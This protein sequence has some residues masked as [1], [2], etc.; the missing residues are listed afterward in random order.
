[1][2]VDVAQAVPGLGQTLI[3]HP[4]VAIT[5]FANG[6]Y[7]YFKQ[8]VGWR[9]LRNGIQFKLFGNGPVTSAGVEAVAFVNPGDP[10]AEPMSQAFC[11][12]VAYLDRDALDKVQD[13]YRL[14]VTTGVVAPKLRG[15]V[16]LRSAGP[17]DMPVASPHL[18]KHDD[19]MAEMNRGQRFYRRA[20]PTKPLAKRIR[21]IVLPGAD[22]D[23]T[24]C[25]FANAS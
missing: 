14:T 12:L 13:D 2:G 5:A 22:D 17:Q 20:F 19:D 11:V 9:T 24:L 7:R 8:G 15:E 1:M 4:E 25:L 21:E 6:P 23:E 16:C 10:D 3:D 18:L